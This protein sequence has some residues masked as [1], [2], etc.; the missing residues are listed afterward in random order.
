MSNAQQKILD[1][2]NVIIDAN[3]CPN[4]ESETSKYD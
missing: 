1:K 2:K 3:R 4:A